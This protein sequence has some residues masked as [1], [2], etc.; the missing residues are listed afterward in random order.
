MLTR[1]PPEI[2]REIIVFVTEVQ[3]NSFLLLHVNSTL[4]QI[5]TPILYQNLVFPS[6]EKL[7]RFIDRCT[8]LSLTHVPRTIALE[9]TS[10]DYLTPFVKMKQLFTVL[11]SHSQAEVDTQGSLAFESIRLRLNS[12]SRSDNSVYEALSMTK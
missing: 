9:L 1:L 8:E 5:T 4:R 7:Q 11:A 2:L 12:F 3:P 6:T 10:S